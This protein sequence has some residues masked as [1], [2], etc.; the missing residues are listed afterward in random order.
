ME[1]TQ[2]GMEGYWIHQIGEVM[3]T[4]IILVLVLTGIMVIIVIIP[5]GGVIGDICRMSSR[6]QN[7]LHLMGK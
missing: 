6:K 2:S 7:H 1:M 3:D 4:C 5:K